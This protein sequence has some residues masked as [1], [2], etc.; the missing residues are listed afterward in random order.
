MSALVDPRLPVFTPEELATF[1]EFF[2]RHTGILF[3]SR[4]DYFVERR[5]AERMEA[6]RSAS[7]ADYFTRLRFQPS[8]EE[9]QNLVNLLTVNETYFYREDYQFKALVSGILPELARARPRGTPISLWSLPCSTG[10]EPYSIAMQILD[11]WDRADEFEIEIHGS[12]IDTRVLAEARRGV[13][14]ERALHR[15]APDVRRRYFARHGTDDWRICEELR[16]SV[17]FSIVNLANPLDTRR[18]RGMDVIFCRNLL[19]Y[20]D[21]LSRRKAV[22]TLYDCLAPGGFLCLGHSE[23]MSRMSS[24]FTARAFGETVVHQKPTQAEY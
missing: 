14:G 23:S 24:L 17:E 15:L 3:T 22:E 1:S 12:D 11:G 8:G 21:D 7:F 13:Y 5:L 19:I 18:F 20:F 4:K 6:T 9:L 2:Y 10:E 16:Q